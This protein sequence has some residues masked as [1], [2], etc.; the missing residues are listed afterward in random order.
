MPSLTDHPGEVARTVQGRP[1]D[2]H[3]R[4]SVG[5]CE[6][7]MG[8]PGAGELSFFC[9]GDLAREDAEAVALAPLGAAGEADG[10]EPLADA[11]VARLGGLRLIPGWGRRGNRQIACRRGPG[12]PNDF[13]LRTGEDPAPGPTHEVQGGIERNPGLEHGCRGARDVPGQ[14]TGAVTAISRGR[15]A[16][17]TL[18]DDKARHG[19]SGREGR[20]K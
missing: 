8:R 3:R 6:V 11:D 7:R 14:E 12:L 19:N 2:L 9:A 18:G 20:L 13:A 16:A 17:E 10:V 5:I 4:E 1:D 15:G